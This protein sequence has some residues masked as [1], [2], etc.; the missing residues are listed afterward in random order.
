MS[1]SGDVT[2]Q[3]TLQGAPAQGTEGATTPQQILS[4]SL[5]GFLYMW[6]IPARDMMDQMDLNWRPLFKVPIFSFFPLL[7]HI[8]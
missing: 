7:D 6:E 5:D 3:P 8:G 4:V 2:R 1:Y